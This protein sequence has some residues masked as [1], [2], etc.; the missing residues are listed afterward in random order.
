MPKIKKKVEVPDVPQ[1]EVKVEPT[2]EEKEIKLLVSTTKKDYLTIAE[3]ILE[4]GFKVNTKL[5]YPVTQNDVP[6]SL[7]ELIAKIALTNADVAIK[8]IN[9]IALG[10]KHRTSTQIINA[11]RLVLKSQE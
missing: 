7:A 2:N 10:G 1:V 8:L 11:I 9:D 3:L 4:L 5:D 6:V